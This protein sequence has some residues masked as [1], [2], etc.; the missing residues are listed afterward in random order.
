MEAYQEQALAY[1]KGEQSEEERRA[2]EDLLTR[3][4]ALRA[5]LE[6]SRDLLDLLEAAN[7]E[8]MVRIVHTMIQQAIERGAS[9]IHVVPGRR[10]GTVFFRVD[11]QLQEFMRPNGELLRPM[12]DRWKVMSDC[13]LT[14][15][16]LPQDGLIRITYEGKEYDLRAIFVP[17]V[18]GERVTAHFLA[19]SRR[20][21]LD[22]LGL[23]AD[24]Q[25]RVRRLIRR[26]SGLVLVAGPVASGK[27][28]LLYA[29]LQDFQASDR[30]RRTILT[31]EDPVKS[32]LE[33]ISQITVDRRVGLTFTAA[34]R[35]IS[36]SDPDV[37]LVGAL[38]DR[39]SAELTLEMALAG[40][41]VLAA[42]T[43]N[44]ALGAVQYLRAM[45]VD[46]FMLAQSLAGV[47]GQRLVRRVCPE[48][49]REYLPSSAA[50]ETIGFSPDEDGPFRRGAGCEACRQTGYA[51]RVGLFEV[52]EVDD[53]L[54]RLIADGAPVDTLCRESFGRAGGSLWDDGREKVRQGLTTVEELTRVLF[55][56]PQPALEPRSAFG[57]ALSARR[58]ALGS[59]NG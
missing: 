17:T 27:T 13:S 28:T 43:T 39:E 48:C 35:A 23:A 41:L 34:L 19:R 49:V 25:E 10:E 20:V 50:L 21:D 46:P 56:Y 5:E 30:E 36:Q 29:L 16:N 22:G 52:L 26:P 55:D 44:S 58:S 9:D 8:H 11:G 2:F 4:A 31:L 51:G 47:V 53:A 7:N 1:L 18:T 42:L 14:E 6:R 3:D 59:D 15:R 45:G 40:R 38:R 12:I 37:V 57:S 33:G 24:Q 54:R 32:V